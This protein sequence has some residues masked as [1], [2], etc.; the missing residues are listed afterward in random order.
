MQPT[1]LK[2]GDS[3]DLE[4]LF[5]QISSE[6]KD[7]VEPA[8]ASSA[9]DLDFDVDTPASAEVKAHDKTAEILAP[10]DNPV[11]TDPDS[12]DVFQRLGG[13]TRTLH[14]ALR[15]LGYDKSV[16]NA[17]DQLPDARAR[18]NYIANLTGQAAE[19]VLSTVEQTQKIQD[20][21]LQKASDLDQAWDKMFSQEMSLDDFKTYALQTHQFFKTVRDSTQ[22]TNSYL[23]EIMLA[24]DFHDLTGQVVNRIATMAQTLEEQLVRLLLDATPAERRP[25]VN[26]MWLSGPAIDTS[27]RTDVCGDQTQVDDLLESLGF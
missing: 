15:E 5:D 18:L 6:R 24:Q 8:A 25:Q 27:G 4:A 23:T 22:Q 12:Y 3:D 7:S 20:N 13:L 9:P 26:D 16:G 10:G 21:I 1:E 11:D 2:S 17:V 14:D 19:K